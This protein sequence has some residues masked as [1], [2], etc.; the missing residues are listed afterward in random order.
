MCVASTAMP[1][2]MVTN[3]SLP[4]L[5]FP[6]LDAVINETLRLYPPVHIATREADR[7]MTVGPYTVPAGTA[8]Q[9]SI[10]G[11]HR[12]WRY[13]P[14]PDAFIPER[15][16]PTADE[17]KGCDF[18]AYMPFGDG[19]RGCIGREYALQEVKITLVTLYQRFHMACVPPFASGEPKIRT[20][21]TL[22]PEGPLM[23]RVAP[24]K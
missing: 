24:R 6:Y 15:F 18:E 21:I 7:E 9:V 19:P 2:L 1:V 8:L 12:S 16:L 23:L 5:Q 11:M 13:W 3:V 20:T 14:D 4:F 22:A 17:S 10:Y